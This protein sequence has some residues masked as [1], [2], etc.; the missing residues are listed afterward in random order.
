MEIQIKSMFI[1]SEDTPIEKN[2]IV[3]EL[4]FV[5]DENNNGYRKIKY[6]PG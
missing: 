2:I 6:I 3:D 5:Q 4:G 1:Q